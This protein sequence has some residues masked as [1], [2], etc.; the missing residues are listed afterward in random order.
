MT[1]DRSRSDDDPTSTAPT[2][3]DI[4]SGVV[5]EASGDRVMVLHADGSHVST[6]SPV[7]AVIWHCLPATRDEILQ[8]LTSRY[9]GVESAVLAADLDRFLAELSAAGLVVGGDAGA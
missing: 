8:E 5:G 3:F 6:L 2:P 4:A 7:G 1:T 9:D